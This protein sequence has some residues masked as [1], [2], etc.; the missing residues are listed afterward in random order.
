MFLWDF[1]SYMLSVVCVLIIFAIFDIEAFLQGNSFGC[2]FA[3]FVF[4]GLASIPQVYCFSFFFDN[5]NRALLW[6][7]ATLATCGFVFFFTSFLL[8]RMTDAS[9][10]VNDYLQYYFMLHPQYNIAMGL[11]NLWEDYWRKAGDGTPWEYDI[12]GK[13]V[14]AN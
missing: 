9:R 5:Q 6:C 7:I 12:S 3:L 1:C 13:M 14:R 4:Y 2:T 11:Y 8:G 10:E